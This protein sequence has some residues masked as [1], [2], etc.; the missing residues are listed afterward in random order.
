MVKRKR[1]FKYAGFALK[2]YVFYASMMF[3]MGLIS[4]AYI[5]FGALT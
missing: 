2:I 5:A 1:F 3:S 4:G